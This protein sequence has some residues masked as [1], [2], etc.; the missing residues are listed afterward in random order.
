VL[1][2]DDVR[3]RLEAIGAV[4]VAK[5]RMTPDYLKRYVSE[6]VD[7]WKGPIERTGVSIS[8]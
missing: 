3:K 5:E 7:K 2:S 4:I 8:Q 6:E 1:A